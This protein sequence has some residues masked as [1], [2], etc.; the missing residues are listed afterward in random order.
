MRIPLL[1]LKSMPYLAPETMFSVLY[2]ARPAPML[3]FKG[4]VKLGRMGLQLELSYGID[5]LGVE[6]LLVTICV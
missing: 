4:E 5:H 6:Y 3:R 1:M 2:R